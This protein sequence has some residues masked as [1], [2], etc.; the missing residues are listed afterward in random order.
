MI[1]I[2][3][4]EEIQH[5]DVKNSSQE[6]NDLKNFALENLHDN[7]GN[8][9]PVFTLK[10][11]RLKAQNYVGIIET[12][13][14]TVIEILPKIDF[15]DDGNK[16]KEIFL[17]MLRTWQGWHGT[18]MAQLNKSSIRKLHRFN[19]R[20]IFFRLFLNDLVLLIQRGLARNYI[21]IEDNIQVFKG[22]I[23]FPQHLK[24]NIIDRT[25]F[26]VEFDEFSINRPANRL[27]RLTIEKLMIQAK[28]P[29]NQQL[30]N[31]L[32]INF[33]DVPRSKNIYDDWTKHSVDRSMQHY[34]TVMQWI[35][36]FLFGHG[37]TTFS[38]K[39]LNQALLFPME[40]IFEDYVNHAFKKYSNYNVI[41]QGR[42]PA[43]FLAT[44]N[45]E[46]VFK[47]KP[48]MS[49]LNWRAKHPRY[50]LDTK[51]KRINQGKDKNSKSRGISQNDMYQMFAYAKKYDCKSV[52]LIYPKTI[53]FNSTFR[54]VFD[55]DNKFELV[56]FPFDVVN[57]EKSV[58]KILEQLQ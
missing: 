33:M 36:I 34:N 8:F 19:M 3:E 51:W 32:I 31:Q 5:S 4:F 22:R 53:D 6:F 52:G 29:L 50:I 10:N 27:I 49:I 40:D 41:T 15:A 57:P 35:G 55:S 45:E 2:K 12:K 54:F 58:K 21:T 7:R 47:L 37:L 9:R 26:Y 44:I 13:N 17:N 16:T 46:N 11:G 1:E 43:I 24:N 42:Y 30:L 28:E 14:K 20:E 38:G 48:D 39:H 56:C 23:L 18:K 25:K